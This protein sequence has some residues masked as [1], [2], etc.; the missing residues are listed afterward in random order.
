MSSPPI[1]VL[2]PQTDVPSLPGE[3]VQDAT[4]TLFSGNPWQ[5]VQCYWVVLGGQ[6]TLLLCTKWLSRRESWQADWDLGYIPSNK[7]NSREVTEQQR[8]PSS[9]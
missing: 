8:S 6:S 7:D 1:P 2:G 9:C 4:A 5:M 3:A